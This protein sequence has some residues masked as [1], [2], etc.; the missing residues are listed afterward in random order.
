MHT[1]EGIHA[2]VKGEVLAPVGGASAAGP[3]FLA[4]LAA[5]RALARFLIKGI[6]ALHFY[7]IY[8]PVDIPKNW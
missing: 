2:L 7:R 8:R 4:R 1:L 5:C 6:G 3:S